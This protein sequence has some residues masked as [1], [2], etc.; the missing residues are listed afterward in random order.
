MNP[1]NW[2]SDLL[3]SDPGINP[4]TGLPMAGDSGIDVGGNPYGT[5]MSDHFD[6]SPFSTD[7][8]SGSSMFDSTGSS[9]DSFGGSDC[10]S[11]FGSNPWD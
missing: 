1:F 6:S 5:D 2:L 9:F 7:A 11:S 8:F 4:A 10:F 3:H